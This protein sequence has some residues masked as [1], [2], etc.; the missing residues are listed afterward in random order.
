VPDVLKLVLHVA[1]YIGMHALCM[2]AVGNA[3]YA[4]LRWST[5]VPSAG[6]ASAAAVGTE[7]L[8]HATQRTASLPAG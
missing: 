1:G 6:H 8:V 4:G 5:W 2:F 3:S 7:V